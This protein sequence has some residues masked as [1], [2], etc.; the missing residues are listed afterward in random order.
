MNWLTEKMLSFTDC[1]IAF[2]KLNFIWIVYSLRGG[3]VL[4]VFPA[5]SAML[6]NF[7]LFFENDNK[8]LLLT[9]KERFKNTYQENFRQ[10]NIVG[11][12]MLV[13]ILFLLVYMRLQSYYIASPWLH[14]FLLVL[15]IIAFSVFIYVF[16]SV[17]R[18]DLNVINHIR[19]AWFLVL[20]SI[21][22]LI[23]IFI[24]M[25]LVLYL[26]ILFPVI[27]TLVA[28]PVYF[29]PL[30]WFSYSSLIKLENNNIKKGD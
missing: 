30:S 19:Q 12:I 26:F 24:G 28:V 2:I 20:C 10:A 13:I 9:D 4:G 16:P 29:L 22:N 6:K 21:P 3:V 8:I 14:F 7:Y 5:L 15:L 25:G 11:Y 27:G 23:A 17:V 18:Y 1:L